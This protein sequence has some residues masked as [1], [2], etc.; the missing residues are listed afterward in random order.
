MYYPSLLPRVCLFTVLKV[1]VEAEKLLILML[2]DS[3]NF[4]FM[5]NAFVSFLATLSLPRSHKYS[6]LC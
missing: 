2:L 3:P 5:I 4:W 6:S 1:S